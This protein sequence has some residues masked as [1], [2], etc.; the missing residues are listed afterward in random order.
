MKNTENLLFREELE[1]QVSK[2]EK[3]NYTLAFNSGIAA[4]ASVM[5]LLEYQDTVLVQDDFYAG[6]RHLLTK[7]INERVKIRAISHTDTIESI[8]DKLKDGSVKV[9]YILHLAI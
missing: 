6:T 9:K 3:A 5:L 8:E 4:I 1:N 2:L 7:I